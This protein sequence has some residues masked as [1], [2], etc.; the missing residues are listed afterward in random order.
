MT[1]RHELLFEAGVHYG[2]R[3]KS[4]NPKMKNFIWGK[5]DGI[6][7]INVALTEI[8]L[9]KAEDLLFK[10]ASEGLPILWVGTKKIA[11]NVVV[12]CAKESESPYFSEHWVGGTLTNYNEVKKSIKNMLQNKEIFEKSTEIL[13]KK[14]LGIIKKR[15]DRAEKGI[16]GIQKLSWPIGALIIADVNRDSVAV[17]E[18]S[19][20]NIPVIALVDTNCDPE[21][22][23][24][25]IPCNDD[26]EKSIEII[27]SYLLEAIL[28]GKEEFKKNNPEKF[29]IKTMEESPIKKNFKKEDFFDYSEKSK[30]KEFKENLNLKSEENKILNKEKEKEKKEKVILKKFDEKTEKTNLDLKSNTKSTNVKKYKE[31]ENKKLEEKKENKIKVKN[32]K[33]ITKNSSKLNKSSHEISAASDSEKSTIKN[34]KKLI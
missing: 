27:F 10:I 9:K 29:I 5:K 26:L 28:K 8:Q 14:E 11:R 12:K 30:K 25:V 31:L 1:N 18:A 19:A 2:H 6:H 13:T 34:K 22:V 24:V 23:K 21:G 16:G 3:T 7:L 33:K 17:K 15:I 32:E 20:M 4:W